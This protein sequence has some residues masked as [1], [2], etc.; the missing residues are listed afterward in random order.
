MPPLCRAA[1]FSCDDE[2][3]RNI[4]EV[5]TVLTIVCVSH[6]LVFQYI[7]TSTYSGRN[8]S[9]MS[10]SRTAVIG[11]FVMI[12]IYGTI[13]TVNICVISFNVLNVLL[14]NGD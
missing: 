11:L 8:L 13:F 4:V 9:P 7:C 6:P 3:K 14:L 12:T 10:P 5:F 2:V 1:R